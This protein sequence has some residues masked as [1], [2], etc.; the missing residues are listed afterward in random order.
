M[1]EAILATL[2][3]M[4]WLGV[5]LAI[6]VVVNTTCGIIRNL[7][8]GQEFSWKVL[9]KGLGKA[10]VYYASAVLTSIAFTMLPFINAQI[11]D[12]FQVE[13]FGNETLQTLS[14]VAVVGVVIASIIVQGKKALDGVIEL[15]GV[16]VTN[17]REITWEVIDP[18]TNEPM[19]KGK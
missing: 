11:A 3:I 10:F 5:V 7:H 15:S 19:E 6:L 8:D 16:S 13:L 18:V 4:G 12:V 9:F 1:W 14:A 17:K 2:G